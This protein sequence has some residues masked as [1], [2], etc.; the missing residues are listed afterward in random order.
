MTSLGRRNKGMTLQGNGIFSSK[1]DTK[2]DSWS[3][4]MSG[5]TA[6]EGNVSKTD[7]PRD[8]RSAS[9]TQDTGNAAET[10]EKS[11]ERSNANQPKDDDARPGRIPAQQQTHKSN[12]GNGIAAN[13]LEQIRE[14]DHPQS[15]TGVAPSD[16][17]PHEESEQELRDRILTARDELQE[18]QVNV[19]EAVNISEASTGVAAKELLRDLLPDVTR[20][21]N[22]SQGALD[23]D[24][25]LA[26]KNAP[27]QESGKSTVTLASR[28]SIPSADNTNVSISNSDP[29]K[30]Q[31]TREKEQHGTTAQGTNTRI[32]TN[33]TNT[34]HDQDFD[35]VA[36]SDIEVERKTG[37]DVNTGRETRSSVEAADV[38]VQEAPKE[39][40][41]K[42][43]KQVSI[44]CE[45]SLPKNVAH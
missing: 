3:G 36:G 18:L 25:T 10:Q 15:E 41:H 1:D 27:I 2:S 12:T 4:N 7:E 14:T 34:K 16:S 23:D 38:V 17:C 35:Q 26:S 11:S 29:D 42:L 20:K 5:D 21:S 22:T 32:H 39:H 45:C 43:K 30:L 33:E 19:R 28:T 40:A 24:Y 6:S 9:T 44:L 8:S 13:Q 37:V 31:S